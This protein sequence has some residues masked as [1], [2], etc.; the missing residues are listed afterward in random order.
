[1]IALEMPL[2]LIVVA[3]FFDSLCGRALATR[4]KPPSPFFYSQAFALIGSVIGSAFSSSRSNRRSTSYA[5]SVLW[6]ALS[7]WALEIFLSLNEIP[8]LVR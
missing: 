7:R 8:S 5:L 4:M 1:M 6:F 2:T 3:T